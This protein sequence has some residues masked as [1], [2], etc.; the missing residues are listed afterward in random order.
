MVAD[1]ADWVELA[2]DLGQTF[3]QRAADYDAGCDFVEANYEDLR[4]HRMFSIGVPS[5]LGGGGATF[6]DVCGVIRTISYCCGSTGLAYAMHSHPVGLNRFKFLKGDEKAEVTLRKIAEKELIIAGTGAND[7]LTSSGRLVRTASGYTVNAHKRFVSGGPG[8]DLMVTSAVLR[9]PDGSEEILH[10]SIP[11]AAKGVKIRN[12]WRT[13][14]MRGTGSNDVL[15]EDVEIPTDAIT[16]RRPV[17]QW[18]TLWDTVLPIA[19][20]M[21]VS[22]YVGIAERA[23]DITLEACRGKADKA[24]QVGEL[25]NALSSARMVLTQMI[26]D[27]HEFDFEPAVDQTCETLTCKTLATQAVRTVVD[28][29]T[30]LVGGPGFFQGHELE[31]ITRDIRAIAF[32]PLPE[33]KQKLFTGR[34]ALGL[35]PLGA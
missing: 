14:G 22:C 28:L 7:W 2:S 1:D 20:P 26:R 8:A 16:G 13:L 33:G 9:N 15:L 12:N 4:K 23:V 25:N 6:E 24:V 3:S 5:E 32:H 27:N 29:A 35:D 21:I 19:L 34:V 30:E 17:G 11:F 10:F 31:R 18:H